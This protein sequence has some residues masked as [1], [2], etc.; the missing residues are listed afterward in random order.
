MI[1]WIFQLTWTE[2]NGSEWNSKEMRGSMLILQGVIG[3]WPRS[4]SQTSIGL[5][6]WHEKKRVV[7]CWGSS[8]KTGRSVKKNTSKIDS[9]QRPERSFSELKKNIHF[10]SMIYTMQQ[11]QSHESILN[12]QCPS[13]QRNS[14]LWRHGIIR[15]GSGYFLGSEKVLGH[16][17]V[18][19]SDPACSCASSFSWK[20]SSFSCCVFFKW[21]KKTI[22]SCSP[23]HPAIFRYTTH[24]SFLCIYIYIYVCWLYTYVSKG[25]PTVTNPWGLR[26]FRR[27]GD[28][29]SLTKKTSA[30][31]L[32]YSFIFPNANHHDF[33]FKKILWCPTCA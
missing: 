8:T 33:Y 5:P 10:Q 31:V 11:L 28:P 27:F 30:A 1:W 6:G 19:F 21:K 3:N 4:V 9:A 15:L 32:L 26:N 2:I 25:Y 20:C 13:A 16:S 17:S 29:P 24:F 23:T 18:P 14:R 12:F 22:R 7:S